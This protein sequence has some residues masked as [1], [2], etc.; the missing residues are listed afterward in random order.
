M[1]RLEQQ[2][3]QA[4]FWNPVGRYAFCA[5]TVI[6][7]FVLRELLT[8]FI[9]RGTPFFLFFAATL[10]TGLA[11]GIGPAVLCI[12]MGLALS[13]AYYTMGLREPSSRALVQAIF[14]TLD[15]A[16]VVYLTVLTRRGR[17]RYEN[18]IIQWKRADEQCVQ[19]FDRTRETI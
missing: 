7:A 16:L 6:L 10:V 14:Y 17:R 2:L 13:M 4:G 11:A 19:A 3:W 18:A 12:V 15:G 9:G 1:D 8:P 5:S